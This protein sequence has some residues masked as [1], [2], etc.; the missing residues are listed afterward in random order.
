M[1]LRKLC[2]QYEGKTINFSK[3]TEREGSFAMEIAQKSENKL[4]KDQIEELRMENASLSEQIRS[5]QL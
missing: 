4:L 5:M 3:K 1:R 2:F